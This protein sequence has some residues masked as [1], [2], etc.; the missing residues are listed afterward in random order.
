MPITKA[1]KE[2]ILSNIEAIHNITAKK[3]ESIGDYTDRSYREAV[4]ANQAS[5][6]SILGALVSEIPTEEE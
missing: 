1:E 3:A 6:L 4:L 5:I 2:E